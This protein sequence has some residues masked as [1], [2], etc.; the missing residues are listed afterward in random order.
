MNITYE[1]LA[2]P[3][4]KG[5]LV[6]RSSGNIYNQSLVASLISNIGVERTEKARAQ[7][8]EVIV[9]LFEFISAFIDVIL[10]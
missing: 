3:K 1:D 8:R 2:D 7:I 10:G 4:W 5:R 9:F 6:V